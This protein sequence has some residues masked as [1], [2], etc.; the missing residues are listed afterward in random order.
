MNPLLLYV[1]PL[2]G[3]VLIGLTAALWHRARS[4]QKTAAGASERLAALETRHR[5][6]ESEQ[7]D[8][9]E[10]LRELPRLTAGPDPGRQLRDIPEILLR[11]LVRLF[12]PREAMVFLRRRP[13]SDK[14]E[15][16]SQ[17]IL[18]A[19][20][21]GSFYQPGKVIEIGQGALG[22][23]AECT[24]PTRGVDL[25]V[26]EDDPR[27]D[28]GSPMTHGDE[29]LGVITLGDLARQRSYDSDLL[30]LLASLGGYALK[31]H[32]KLSQVRTVAE[33]DPLTQVYNRAALS[34]RL[35]QE[36][37]RAE[38]AGGKLSVLLFD[39]DHFKDYNARNGHLAG[40]E[41]LRQLAGFVIERIRTEDIFGRFSGQQFLI[42]LPGR[43]SADAEVAGESIRSAISRR[44]F[45]FGDRQPKGRITIS[46]GVASAPEDAT[47][48]AEL[49]KAAAI[50][51]AAAK[52]SGRNQILSSAAAADQALASVVG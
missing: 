52:R 15:R 26:G 7:V 40:D 12:Q 9:L 45:L 2:V 28:L 8:L 37:L 24:R 43:C 30:W 22:C 41:L 14:P 21:P 44:D 34:L 25:P 49:L 23:L 32:L 3:L 19:A 46:G 20:H 31:S 6:L 42:I 39:L 36:I 47:G 27:I 50:A 38:S 48:S 10:L 16:S 18:T 5:L 1:V 4:A 11:A 13:T 35:A 29:V 33:L 51:L 17:L